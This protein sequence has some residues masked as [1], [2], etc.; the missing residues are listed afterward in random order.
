MTSV[1]SAPAASDLEQYRRELTGYCYRMLG[2]A[3]EADDAVQDTMVRAWKA[4]DRFE[5]RSSLR[6]WLYRI[7]TNVCLDV[8]AA[9]QRRARPM[10]LGPAG[11][12]EAPELGTLPESTW[13]TP[14]P[15]GRVLPEV[16]DPADLAVARDS[17]RLAFVA[18]LQHLPPR[19]RAVLILREVLAWP[20]AEVA[21]LLETS[22]ASVN[23]ALQR[24]RATVAER[25]PD[26]E[27]RPIALGDADQALLERY[28]DAF[29]RYDMTTLT[30]LIK[31][32]AT[33]AM[34]P[35]ELWLAGRDQILTFW[36]GAGAACRGS[37]LVPTW[38][39]GMP[40]FAQYRASGPGGSYEPWALQVLDVRDGQVV[41]FMFFLDTERVFPLFGIPLT[42]AGR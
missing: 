1:T 24:A 13:I 18:A 17:I 20:A 7:A 34:P 4:L 11:S 10:D 22:V 6:S 30:T 33:Q 37:K 3:F 26:V 38:A 21:E 9:R 31:H 15:D 41:D 25:D 40:A 23:S 16:A 5:G 2:S 28:V 12:A 14:I 29:Q 27:A 8:A 36:Q 35:Y 39:N 19:Q 42:P 32:D